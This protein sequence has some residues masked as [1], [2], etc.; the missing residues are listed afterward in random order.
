M[1]PLSGKRGLVTGAGTRVGAE[2]ARALGLAG[3]AV[4]VHHH[5]S[6]LGAEA[7]CRDITEAGGQAFTVQADLYDESAARALVAQVLARLGGLDLLVASA[8]NF[9][10]VSWSDATREHWDRALQLNLLAPFA[11]AQE[12]ASAL[13]ASSGSIVL[14]TCGTRIAPI[15]GYLPYQ[16]SKAAAHQM[17]RLLARA[18]APEVR[19][20]AVAPGTVLPPTDMDD[21]TQ[22]DLVGRIPLRRVGG[23]ASVADA[24]LYLAAASFVTGTEV[25]V[26]GGRGL[27]A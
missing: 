27:G 16:V 19:V 24:V 15:D 23:A 7:T 9:D 4:A 12:A 18:L 17:M 13:K 21:A 10:A 22:R 2:I 14:I 20:N 1:Q 26:D 6:A 25:V 5:A 8:G 11:L 3:M